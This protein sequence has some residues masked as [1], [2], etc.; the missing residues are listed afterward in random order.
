MTLTENY[1]D[2]KLASFKVGNIIAGFRDDV[3]LEGE[4]LSIRG[5]EALIKTNWGNVTVSLIG[6]RWL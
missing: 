3:E 1:T 2:R 4:I 5:S 6:A